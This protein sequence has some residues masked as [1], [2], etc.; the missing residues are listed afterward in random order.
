MRNVAWTRRRGIGLRSA[1]SSCPR[2]RAWPKIARAHAEDPDTRDRLRE[3]TLKRGHALL[4]ELER[5]HVLSGENAPALRAARD[6]L[7]D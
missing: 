1:A 4:T 5:E 3:A 6:A 7:S 2:N